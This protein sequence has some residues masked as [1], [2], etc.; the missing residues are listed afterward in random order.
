VMLVLACFIRSSRSTAHRQVGP[1]K[2]EKEPVANLEN[3][4]RSATREEEHLFVIAANILLKLFLYLI[5]LCCIAKSRF[6][7][8]SAQSSS[9]CLIIYNWLP[10]LL[11]NSNKIQGIRTSDWRVA[12]NE[13]SQLTVVK[14]WIFCYITLEKRCAW[15]RFVVQKGCYQIFEEP[16]LPSW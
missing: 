12:A 2:E 9:S 3:R 11:V 5:C 10:I 7:T 8:Y 16:L 15:L 4:F 6:T 13:E 1:R 14:Y